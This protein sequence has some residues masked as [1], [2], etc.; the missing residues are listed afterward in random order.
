MLV[1]LFGRYRHLGDLHHTFEFYKTPFT[2]IY[3]PDIK[4][5]SDGLNVYPTEELGI[6]AVAD[7]YNIP[8]QVI[9]DKMIHA[10][11]RTAKV[12]KCVLNLSTKRVAVFLYDNSMKVWPSVTLN[13]YA[14]GMVI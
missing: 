12:R 5:T 9:E 6:S 3:V 2:N 1:A 11:T 13:D 10:S 14:I 4:L 7:I 8:A